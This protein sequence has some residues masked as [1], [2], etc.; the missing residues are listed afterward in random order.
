MYYKID[1]EIVGQY[2]K[3]FL[4]EMKQK[5]LGTTEHRSAEIIVE[6]LQLPVAPEDYL[7]QV[8]KLQLERL[9]NV[10]PMPGTY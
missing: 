9:G 8:K 10:D 6:M 3:Q 5:V 1:C 2:G 4:K 7:I